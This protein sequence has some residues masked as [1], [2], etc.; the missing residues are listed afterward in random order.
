MAPT[1]VSLRPASH[2]GAQGSLPAFATT[3]GRGETKDVAL[4]LVVFDVL[5]ML[6]DRKRRLRHARRSST[7]DFIGLMGSTAVV[8]R[9]AC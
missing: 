6:D 7:A 2:P 1:S 4:A 3:N 8:H 5:D 9:R